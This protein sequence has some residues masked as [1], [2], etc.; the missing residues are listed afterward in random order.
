[1]RRPLVI[2]ASPSLAVRDYHGGCAYSAAILEELARSGC[3]VLQVWLADLRGRRPF[4]LP[5][6]SV[7]GKVCVSGA[8]RLGRLVIPL[9]RRGLDQAGFLRR[10]VRRYQPDLVILDRAPTAGIWERNPQC[11]GWVLTIDSLHRRAAMYESHGYEKDFEVAAE[12]AEKELLARG[13]G[14]IAIQ[15]D[16][17]QLFRQM[18][19]DTP[20]IT[21]PHPV[22]CDPLPLDESIPG[23]LLFIGGSAAHNVD[24]IQWFVREVFPLVLKKNPGVI[25]E[26]AGAVAASVPDHPSVQ[27]LGHVSNL[28]ALYGRAQ[29]CIAPLR[30]GT[31][32]KIK[33]MEAMGYGRPVVATPVAAEGFADLAEALA[34]VEQS[35]DAMAE[36]IGNLI[37]NESFRKGVVE[38]QFAW[39]R[40]HIEPEV[41]IRPLLEQIGRPWAGPRVKTSF[42]RRSFETIRML[43]LLALVALVGFAGGVVFQKRVT[44]GYSIKM[45]RTWLKLDSEPVIAYRPQ[46]EFYGPEETDW[47]PP[48]G[49]IYNVEAAN[50]HRLREIARLG[51]QLSAQQSLWA[52]KEVQSQLTEIHAAS[53]AKKPSDVQL[54][55]QRYYPPLLPEVL[56]DPLPESSSSVAADAIVS[57]A[58]RLE[59]Q[60]RHL[61]FIPLPNPVDIDL[62]LFLEKRIY[63]SI[64][65]SDTALFLDL[66][67]RGVDVIDLRESFARANLNG[68]SPFYRAD[69]HWT[70]EGM[71]LAAR[72]VSELLQGRESR[73]T[74]DSRMTRRSILLPEVN[75]NADFAPVGMQ[76]GDS[77]AY[78]IQ[79]DGKPLRQSLDSPVLVLGDS[80]VVH[81]S[82]AQS[83]FTSQLAY[84]LVRPLAY[85]GQ[86]GGTQH[87]PRIYDDMVHRTGIS[88]QVV[89]WVA[90][91][92][93][94]RNLHHAI[95]SPDKRVEAPVRG[96]WHGRFEVV[97]TST[98]PLPENAPYPDALYAFKVRSVDSGQ[99]AVVVTW[100]FRDRQETAQRRVSAGKTLDLELVAWEESCETQPNLRR[101][102]RVDT[103]NEFALPMFF[104]DQPN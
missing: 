15:D 24:G 36:T 65:A 25:L 99:E 92:G 91:N 11:K 29:I 34:G 102:Q 97:A 87:V 3:E 79:W 45:L 18:L 2:I 20:V 60:G 88:P 61:I 32:L 28:R 77:L 19:P 46:G 26:I 84:E 35:P 14:I 33:V 86:M 54:R 72:A 68:R 23:T 42:V 1:M 27:K 47:V 76:F 74:P 93:G 8:I 62:P 69:H 90:I 22:R 10:A 89:I 82:T 12:V 13:D 75:C 53:Q 67:K 85:F 104:W 40:R 7:G 55:L 51:S 16:E 70:A 17:A 58:Q 59:G 37:Q 100:A 44:V 94:W 4:R 66:L 71:D 21:V 56:I 95:E 39:V 80:N 6:T 78:Q 101:L 57:F 30:F 49:R 31:G 96:K 50:E 9:P 41:A 64:A 52:S 63:S 43:M 73:Q 103:L 98:P 83:D 38:L 48:V 81:H 5:K